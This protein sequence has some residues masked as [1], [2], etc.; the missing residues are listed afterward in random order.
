MPELELLSIQKTDIHYIDLRDN[1]K[2]TKF[3]FGVG[4]FCVTNPD[5]SIYYNG[6]LIPV[7]GFVAKNNEF[8]TRLY[9]FKEY[10]SFGIG[11][12]ADMVEDQSVWFKNN[13]IVDFE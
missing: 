6:T 10:I 1:N 7:G 5:V 8:C 9:I 12:E 4:Q 3:N 13:I 2:L 11:H